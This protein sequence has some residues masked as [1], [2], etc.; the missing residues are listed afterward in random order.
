MQCLRKWK[1]RAVIHLVCFSL[2][3]TPLLVHSLDSYPPKFSLFMNLFWSSEEFGLWTLMP[4]VTLILPLAKHILETTN[5]QQGHKIFVPSSLALSLL[6]TKPAT[7]MVTKKKNEQIQQTLGRSYISLPPMSSP[8]GPHHKKP[9]C[10]F[11]F[12]ENQLAGC[13]ST[14][15]WNDLFPWNLQD[16]KD[17]SL[18]PACVTWSLPALTFDKKGR[19]Q[20]PAASQ[21]QTVT[22]QT[23]VNFTDL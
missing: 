14:C 1:Q 13:I 5:I 7:N 20:L 21:H 16:L 15:K 6:P 2:F 3:F 12:H 10:Y 19:L 17:I 11:M 8:F 22:F 23:T 4:K 9:S 18:L